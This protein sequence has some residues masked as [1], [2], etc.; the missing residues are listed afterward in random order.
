M[1]E[2]DLLRLPAKH[3]IEKEVAS[4]YV[5]TIF[6]GISQLA[7]LRP[8]LAALSSPDPVLRTTRS[9]G[10]VRLSVEGS[11][12][13]P[14][15]VECVTVSSDGRQLVCACYDEALVYELYTDNIGQVGV[16]CVVRRPR[17]C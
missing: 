4:N 5:D 9:M 17:G 15:Y 13:T 10:A 2:M 16:C 7:P 11:V 3:L 8:S 12:D 14:C 6:V 1:A